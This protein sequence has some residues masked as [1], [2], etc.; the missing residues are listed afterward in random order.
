MTVT[1]LGASSF[2]KARAASFRADSAWSARTVPLLPMACPARSSGT[3]PRR[4]AV[5]KASVDALLAGVLHAGGPAVSGIATAC[6]DCGSQSELEDLL[7]EPQSLNHYAKRRPPPSSMQKIDQQLVWQ[8]PHCPFQA[9]RKCT[10]AGPG[11]KAARQLHNVRA[12]HLERYHAEQVRIRGFS[13]IAFVKEIDG[14]DAGFAWQCP[15]CLGGY[16]G[17]EW[18]RMSGG[19][20][21][22]ARSRHRQEAHAELTSAQWISATRSQTAARPAYR[23]LQQRSHIAASVAARARSCTSFAT[24]HDVVGYLHPRVVKDKKRVVL[25]TGLRC[26]RCKRAFHK[27]RASCSRP[28]I[29]FQQECCPL[30]WQEIRGHK[31]T[32]AHLCQHRALVPM[33]GK[34]AAEAAKLY[35]LFDDAIAHFASTGIPAV[36]ARSG[37]PSWC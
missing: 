2:V 33:Y 11:T 20:R 24:K 19:A 28:E 35:R 9:V 29:L 22:A 23:E 31:R 10:E 14:S 7:P 6:A 1:M 21:S 18:A 13:N 8:C 17:P 5:G 36:R 16:V 27:T 32:H 3:G 26:L 15:V 30:T 25:E 34:G 12:R 37:A 4:K